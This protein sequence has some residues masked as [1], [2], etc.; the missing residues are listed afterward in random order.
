MQPSKLRNQTS[1]SKHIKHQLVHVSLLLLGALAILTLQARA[2][3]ANPSVRP[4]YVVVRMLSARTIS[5]ANEALPAGYRAEDQLLAP[6]STV[7]FSGQAL[8]NIDSRSMP[9][10]N[11]KL[12]HAEDQLTRTF[13]VSFVGPHIP[14]VAAHILKSKY[15]TSVECAEP[16]YLAVTQGTPDD[17]LV[18][19]QEYLTTVKAFEGWSTYEGNASVVIG[20]SDD[21][22]SQT[23]EDLASNIAVNVGEIPDNGI[24]DDQ[25][26]FIDDHI[27][28]N[29]L[30]S[31][32]SMCSTS[33]QQMVDTGQRWQALLPLQRIMELALRGWVFVLGSSQ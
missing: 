13:T 10:R 24:D 14:A 15:A 16:W 17:P 19:S 29:N 4:H 26:G 12:Y 20:I 3:G 2:Q 30:T 33:M 21:G 28:F 31:D 11:A 1:M 6:R 18:T 27:G 9:S 25:N 5:A 7:N 32:S 8:L 23:H 22:I